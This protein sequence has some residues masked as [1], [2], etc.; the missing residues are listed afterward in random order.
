MRGY[1]I[2]N[3]GQ[4][5][6]RPRIWLQGSEVSRAGLRSGDSYSV[7]V[8]GGSIVL[9]ADP[10]GDRVVSAKPAGSAETL[11]IID[12]NSQELLAL[13]DGGKRCLFPRGTFPPDSPA[14]LIWV[15]SRNF[16]GWQGLPAD[17]LD[18]L[19]ADPPSDLPSY[20]SI[21]AE[22]ADCSIDTASSHHSY[23]GLSI[24]GARSLKRLRYSVSVQ[25]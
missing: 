22:E 9:R 6:G 8:T 4:N 3:I 25:C 11:P 12:I 16:A 13:F 15:C 5:R 18:D 23:A 17:G 10:N 21:A 19:A 1:Y 7:H 14:R 2:K 24:D 20:V